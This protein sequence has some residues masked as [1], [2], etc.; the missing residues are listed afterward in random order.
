MVSWTFRCMGPIKND[1][2][3]FQRHLSINFSFFV[4]TNTNILFSNFYINLEQRFSLTD[5]KACAGM[6]SLILFK[7]SFVL[8]EHF[9][10]KLWLWS[11]II[12]LEKSVSFLGSKS[13]F[14]NLKLALEIKHKLV[15]F[16]IFCSFFDSQKWIILSIHFFTFSSD[17]ADHCYYIPITYGGQLFYQERNFCVKMYSVEYSHKLRRAPFHSTATPLLNLNIGWNEPTYRSEKSISLV[18]NQL[19]NTYKIS[20]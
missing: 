16:E 20:S 19:R 15:N 10:F 4:F 8:S 6:F 7:Y 13:A 14:S 9:K 3:L 11:L 12:F 18:L 17:A 1:L 5:W 2:H